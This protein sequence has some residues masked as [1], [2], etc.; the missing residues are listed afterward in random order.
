[1]INEKGSTTMSDDLLPNTSRFLAGS[2][3]KYRES[4]S[5]TL[6]YLKTRYSVRLDYDRFTYPTKK[7]SHTLLYKLYN[8]SGNEVMWVY[9][10]YR[11]KA[12]YISVETEPEYLHSLIGISIIEDSGYLSILSRELPGFKYVHRPVQAP[13]L[14]MIFDDYE[15]IKDSLMKLCDVIDEHFFGPNVI[16]REKMREKAIKIET[17]IDKLDLHGEDR[18]AIVKVRVNQDEF[19]D[20]LLKRYSKCCLCGVSEPSLL[21]ASHIKPWAESEPDEKLDVD[22]GF[23]LC[24]NHDKL[25]DRGYISFTDEGNIMISKSLSDTDSLFMNVNPLMRVELNSKNKEYLAF[26]RDN[27]FRQ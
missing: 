5:K 16:R 18:E 15:S 11:Q 26:H 2:D 22:N 21:T 7:Y 24:P 13:R 1:M 20:R 9:H 23:L 6:N 8:E 25:F 17:E 27:V 12:Q 19:R 10:I 3:S 14:K 4:L